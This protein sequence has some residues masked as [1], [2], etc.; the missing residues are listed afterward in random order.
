MR[1]ACLMFLAL[2]Y[3]ATAADLTI[4]PIGE[5]RVLYDWSAQRCDD[6][7]IPDAPVRAFRRADGNIALIATHRKN[8]MMVG[9]DIAS[10]KPVCASILDSAKEPAGTGSLWI[11]AV[12]TRDGRHIAALLSQDLADEMKRTGCDPGGR[13]GRCWL[14]NILAAE[15]TNM[16]DTFRVLEKSDRVIATL[17]DA[18]SEENQNRFGVFTAS[19]IVSKDGFYYMIAFAQGER[20]QQTGNCLFRTAD[21]MRPELWR[22]WDGVGFDLDMRRPPAQGCFPLQGLVNEVRSLNYV[23][24]AK[25]WVAVFAARLKLKGDD[26][27]VP[28]FYYAVSDDLMDWKTP[29]RIMPAPTRPR[30]QNMTHYWSY[31]AIIDP[32]S[33][34]LNFESIDSEKPYLIFTSRK[35]IDGM[36]TMDRDIIYVPLNIKF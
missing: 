32:H 1:L 16:G 34:R 28:G 31:P 22:A 21:P 9:P 14:N 24:S 19:N 13:P 25:K 29:S 18:Y 2:I 10:L 35:L 23:T 26:V 6:E 36:G 30:E 4:V 3:P 20:I 27:P 12:F 5:P 15:S 17:S 7:F 33:K 8:W 11:E